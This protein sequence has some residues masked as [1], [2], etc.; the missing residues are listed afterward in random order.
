M[1]NKPARLISKLLE[2]LRAK[3]TELATTRRDLKDMTEQKELFFQR[4]SEAHDRIGTLTIRN[5]LLEREL[6]LV[7]ERVQDAV[8]IAVQ[9]TLAD[10]SARLASEQ[11]A[12]DAA[13]AK[14]A[15]PRGEL[16]GLS[17]AREVIDAQ[18]A[19]L[20]RI[21]DSVRVRLRKKE[22]E[23]ERAILNRQALAGARPGLNRR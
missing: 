10:A 16:D 22:V 20:T 9:A 15:E 1:T 18:R 7:P 17:Q 8:D 21:L 6:T 13:T 23:E 5:S 11:V 2:S 12:L 4:S 3:E 19:E 14:N